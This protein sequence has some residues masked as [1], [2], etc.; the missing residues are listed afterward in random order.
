[1]AEPKP[2]RYVVLVHY[3]GTWAVSFTTD[4]QVEVEE[5]LRQANAKGVVTWLVDTDPGAPEKTL[6]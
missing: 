2:D 3:F 1:V 5:G 4:Y 6:A